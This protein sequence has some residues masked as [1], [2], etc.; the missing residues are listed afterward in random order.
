MKCSF[1][2][3]RLKT[4]ALFMFLAVCTGFSQ[5][6]LD[7]Y[8]KTA[9]DNNPT[10]KENLALTEKAVI[11]QD[12][13]KAEFRKPKVFA[14]GEINY[15]PLVPN[16]D[17]PNAIGYDVAITDGALYA[18]LV[19][20]QQPVFN[21]SIYETLG[22]QAEVAGEAGA[23]KAKLTLHQLEKE[24]T[25]QYIVS[26]QSLNQITFVS[27]IK[28]QL[29]QQK[30]VIE[31][32]AANGIYKRSDILLI[33]I[34]IQNQATEINNLQAIYNRN[35][36]AL[37]ELCGLKENAGATLSA[38]QIELKTDD[39]PSQFLEK[40]RLDS[41]Q[42]V[43][44]LEV[45][46]LKYKPQVNIY[47]NTGLQA[48]EFS[49]I[50]RKFGVGVG[51]IL[52]IPIYDGHQ[53]DFTRKQTEINL[54]VIDSYRQNF[55][56]QKSNRQQAILSDLKLKEEKINMIRSQLKNYEKLMELYKTELQTGELQIIDYMNTVKSYTVAQ[57]DLTISETNKMLIINE[58]NYYN[59]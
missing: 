6:T 55:L 50:Q 57:R 19:N 31:T 2:N 16:K 28:N 29:I 5:N 20:I 10:I 33:E 43:Y 39:A 58:N 12:I 54:G 56:V 46:N 14:T 52:A 35:I 8:L 13:V 32:L 9:R 38:P 51:M 42:Q 3:K 44:N 15:S 27:N 17:D 7:Y 48:I 30:A 21:K 22:R 47:G 53:K 4:T 41:L 40:F 11:Q 45:S 26:Y 49:G 36:Y 18:G 34:E 23:D 25:D 1:K 37:N 24:V 59:W